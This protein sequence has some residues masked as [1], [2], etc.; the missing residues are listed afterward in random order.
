MF[1]RRSFLKVALAE[2]LYRLKTRLD[3][4][5]DRHSRACGRS[6]RSS[7]GRAAKRLG[8]STCTRTVT[9]WRRA[10]PLTFNR[11]AASDSGL[12]LQLLRGAQARRAGDE[13]MSL[14]A[15]TR[16]GPYEIL[17]AIG[18]GGM[19]EVYRARD[20]K[21][22]RDLALNILP[23]GLRHRSRSPGALHARSADARVGQSSQHRRDLRHRGSAARPRPRHG[24]VTGRV[25]RVA[26]I[27]PSSRC[28]LAKR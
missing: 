15:V 12:R 26:Q 11:I 19:G 25:L 22:H 28:Q 1:R 13:A 2:R 3:A 14:S 24:T 4:R 6:D 23:G 16:L 9:R 5:L 17:S 27:E 8:V 20:T 10:L 7:R 18:A 21:L